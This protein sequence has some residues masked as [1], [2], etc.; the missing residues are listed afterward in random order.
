[1]DLSKIEEISPPLSNSP[2]S[3]S[4]PLLRETVS[5]PVLIA[6][7]ES[8]S[9][10]IQGQIS[11]EQVDEEQQQKTPSPEPLPIVDTEPEQQPEQVQQESVPEAQ[12]SEG[13]QRV[14]DAAT[15]VAQTK[16]HGGGHDHEESEDW[17]V[18]AEDMSSLREALKEFR[19]EEGK[20]A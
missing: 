17:I 15:R 18:D 9:D 8:T 7:G 19:G 14:L 6:K 12:E 13:L 11:E 3:S 16:E 5:S 20:A 10:F 2:L 4:K 1:M